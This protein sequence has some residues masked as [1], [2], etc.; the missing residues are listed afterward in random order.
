MMLN[1]T[2][3]I[4]LKNYPF[5]ENYRFVLVFTKDL[6]LLKF[7]IKGLGIKKSR[8]ITLTSPLTHIEFSYTP[9][10]TGDLHFFNDIS[11]INAFDKLKT[12]YTLLEGAGKMLRALI[13]SQMPAVP[14]PKL[15]DLFCMYLNRLNSDAE[16][17]AISMSFYLKILLHEG[18]LSLDEMC[19]NCSGNR[20][21]TFWQQQPVCQACAPQSVL[22]FSEPEWQAMSSLATVKKF[23]DFSAIHI[24]PN[25]E[26]KIR[27]FFCTVFA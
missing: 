22:S 2:S 26:E 19:S 24:P 3:G 8:L 16:M 6:G 21:S 14:A 25:L 17:R 12:E 11:L 9:A 18:L 13:D 23:S 27:D 5:K 20:P 4:V 10:R 7:M 1:N 15:F